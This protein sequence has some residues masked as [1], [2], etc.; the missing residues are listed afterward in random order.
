MVL[1]V[2]RR[3]VLAGEVFVRAVAALGCPGDA[4]LGGGFAVAALK[5]PG[6]SRGRA[7]LLRGRSAVAVAVAVGVEGDKCALIHGPLAV[8]VEAVAGLGRPGEDGG[9][10]VVAVEA[11]VGAVTVDV[12]DAVVVVAVAVLV[13]VVADLGGRGMLPR[14]GGLPARRGLARPRAAL[15]TDAAAR[16]AF[17]GNVAASATGSGPLNCGAAGCSVNLRGGL[18]GAQAA[19]LGLSYQL[20][21]PASGPTCL[22]YTTDA[23]DER[24]RV[25]LGGGRILK[26]KKKHNDAADHKH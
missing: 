21:A 1:V 3:G 13:D 8:V 11:D 15:T 23:A 7:G 24:P 26:K 5:R 16:F 14:T 17:S 22:F 2:V 20:Q 12:G 6:G 9:V 4:R 18:F 10:V 25:T 19:R